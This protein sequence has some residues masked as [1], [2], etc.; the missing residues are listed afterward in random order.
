[1]E[2]AFFLRTEK[3]ALSAKSVYMVVEET[4]ALAQD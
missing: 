2:A 3:S 1:M 4:G